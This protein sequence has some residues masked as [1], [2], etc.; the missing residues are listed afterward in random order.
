LGTAVDRLVDTSCFLVKRHVATRYSL[1][2]MAHHYMTDR[3]F[4]MALMASKARYGCTGLTTVNY[5]VGVGGSPDTPDY[6]AKCDGDA[7]RAFP[8]GFPWR[9]PTVFICPEQSQS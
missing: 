5:R 4:T 3:G 8:N 2:W 1:A 9:K 7:H 6:Y